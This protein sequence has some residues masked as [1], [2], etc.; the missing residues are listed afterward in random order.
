LDNNLKPKLIAYAF[1]ALL[2]NPIAA[3]ESAPFSSIKTD[4]RE[5][6]AM[7]TVPAGTYQMGKYINY[8][9]GDMD[10]PTHEIRITKGFAVA[11][12]EVTVAEFRNFAQETGYV[13]EGVCNIYT[14]AGTTWHIDPSV[15]WEKPGFPQEENH[16]VVCVSW[17][18]TQAYIKWLNDRTGNNY[19]LPS[20]AEWEYIA[21]TGGLSVGE[22][23]FITHNEGNIG[24]VE[25]CGGATSGKD[26]WQYTAPIRSF[27][28]DKYNLH[29]IRGNVWEWQADCYQPSYIDAPVDGSAR[30]ECDD[31][32]YKVVRGGSYGDAGQ[33]LSPRFRLRGPRTE[34]YFTVG[35]RVAHSFDG[36]EEE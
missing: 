32:N 14:T 11:T 27:S 23:Q 10:G 28:P 4:C 12:A 18:D 13:S 20:E 6:V 22:D 19:R 36:N 7:S 21:T 30:I 25:C 24:Q 9:Y 31:P 8:G 3:Q 17:D 34:A 15:N 35:F 16:P 33:Y 29:D 5:C 2:S 1:T 26:T